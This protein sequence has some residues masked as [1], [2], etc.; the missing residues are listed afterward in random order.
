MRPLRTTALAGGLGL[1]LLAGVTGAVPAHAR[2]APAA[3]STAA[4][5]GVVARVVPAWSSRIALGTCAPAAS[6]AER[7]AVARDGG[8]VLISGSSPSALLTGVG[9]YLKYT[10][11]VDVSWSSDASAEPVAV[12]GRPP[13]PSAPV[14]RTA[15]VPRR[16]LSNDTADGYTN[17][18]WDWN[19]WQR[20]IDV[21][22]LHGVNAFFL[23]V[24]AEAV[25]QRT[26]RAFGYTGAEMRAW[27]PMPAHQPW[28]LLQN[29]ANTTADTE[30]QGLIDARA[31][32]GR[33]IA[34]R[35]R[36]VG[37]APVLP[38]YFGTV[39]G[40]FT[41]RNPGASVVPQG[42]W[43]GTPRPDWLD[44]RTPVFSRVAA[45]F[46]RTQRQLLGP[47]D[48]FKM[49]L[50]HEGGN[51]GTVP[52]PAA[53]HA[54]Q[55]AL[56]T[57]H[58]G[59]TWVILGW[60]HNPTATLLAGVDR[61][62]ML[63]VDGLTDRYPDADPSSDP[64]TRFSGT[65][66]AFGSIWNFGGHT[67]IGANAAVWSS[68]FFAQLAR[69]ASPLTGIAVLPEADDNNDAAFEYL[70]EL[71]WQP[72]P[73][74]PGPAAFAAW[75][76][77]FADAR[78]GVADPDAEAAW[79]TIA[80]T[81]YAMPP[82][83]WSEAPDGLFAARPSLTAVRASPTSPGRTRYD[84]AAF[85]PAL[86]ELLR[87]AP[88]LGANPLYRYD[89]VDVARQVLSNSSRDWLP[90]IR[91]AYQAQDR[92]LFQQLSAQWLDAM[93]TMDALLATRPE[94][95]LG[96]WLR[97]GTRAAA[98]AGADDGAVQRDLR[99]LVTSW[100]DDAGVAARLS[101]YANRE[102]S[103]L[104]GTYYLDRWSRYFQSLDTALASHTAPAPIDWFALSHTW[105]HTPTS[106]PTTPHGTP[107]PLA[108]HILTL[109]SA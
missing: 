33:R 42:R 83:G 1:A 84:T 97:Y 23:P 54:V 94:F 99:T 14:T 18:Y 11:H 70:T 51:P 95:L 63:V 15:N 103:G 90:R 69:P 87:A 32:L 107:L 5:R 59:A 73:A 65:P 38:G 49:D 93:R 20:E 44:P 52:V 31:A 45:A 16:V 22:A 36:E 10:A 81:A 46:Y 19:R 91:A 26:M 21:A 66:Y 96:R 64:A 92:P 8:R 48:A 104:V 55:S 67:A 39:P 78:Y 75:F 13:L 82:D 43:S 24:G 57:A 76:R 102:W 53:A 12:R 89:L 27:I 100:E 4:A 34:D 68:R 25:Y 77:Q 98:A 108:A 40:G 47:S 6:G 3:F 74:D 62:R 85:A 9:A 17:A 72:P 56:E 35:M 60:Q 41:A 28:W 7:Y 2:T 80:R 105:T 30:S 86:A 71:A 106:F 58:P 29:M 61:S 79:Q 50:L 37:I 101:D 109:T 88:R